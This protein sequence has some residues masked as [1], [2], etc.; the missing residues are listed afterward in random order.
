MGYL[1]MPVLPQCGHLI[2]NGLG[3]ST[4]VNFCLHLGQARVFV[5]P[6]A[7]LGAAGEPMISSRGDTA[8]LGAGA[9]LGGLV[10]PAGLGGSLGSVA[11]LGGG[12]LVGTAAAGVG[13]A[14][15]A[16]TRPLLPQFGHWMS[17]T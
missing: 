14:V 3:F 6:P 11:G 10:G 1:S 16:P 8:G 15:L 4:T 13:G 12:P 2:S 17:V 7:G 9:G 5:L